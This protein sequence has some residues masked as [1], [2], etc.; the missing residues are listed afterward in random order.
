MN[1]KDDHILEEILNKVKTTQRQKYEKILDDNGLFIYD[2]YTYVNSD[3]TSIKVICPITYATS[4][5]NNVKYEISANKNNDKE[6]TIF[7]NLSKKY[8]NKQ[9]HINNIKSFIFIL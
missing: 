9:I 3:R 8:S 1:N 2:P 5:A 7:F 6:E 4:D